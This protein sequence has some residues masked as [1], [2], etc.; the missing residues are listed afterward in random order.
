MNDLSSMLINHQHE[1][2]IEVA[3]RLMHSHL[4]PVNHH[5]YHPLRP[6]A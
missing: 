6:M 4:Y 1:N 5:A 2:E 3:R